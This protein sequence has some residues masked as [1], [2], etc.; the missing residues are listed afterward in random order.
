MNLK[1][2]ILNT[3]ELGPVKWEDVKK[4]QPNKGGYICFVSAKSITRE[5]DGEPQQILIGYY[6]Q[7][8]FDHEPTY[9]ELVNY[10]I[11]KEY[12]NGKEAQMLR[13]G[14]YDPEDPE[15]LA[16]YENVE[17]ILTEVKQLFA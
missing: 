10:I 3:A 2:I 5:F 17:Q 16:Y 12:P 14:I 7:T 8:D 4:V 13:F 11:Q 1:N 9:K 15:Y 6:I